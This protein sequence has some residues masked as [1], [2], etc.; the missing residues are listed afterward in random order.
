VKYEIIV[1]LQK[2]VL[3]PEAR[4]IRTTLHGVGFKDLRNL[5][6]TRRYIVEFEK[7]TEN[8]F[9]QAQKIA[10]KFLANPVSQHFKINRVE[11]EL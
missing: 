2:E 6:V 7:D 4:A 5:S 8:P 1:Q 10:Q 11:D 9:E 3:D